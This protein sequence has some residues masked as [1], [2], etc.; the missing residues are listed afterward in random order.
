MVSVNVTIGPLG[1]GFPGLLRDFDAL[2]RLKPSASASSIEDNHL[3]KKNSV[4]RKSELTSLAVF[5]LQFL[6]FKIKADFFFV[7]F[8]VQLGFDC[9]MNQLYYVL[10]Y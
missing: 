9:I 7:S 5:P 3:S 1:F 4:W 2:F 6:F 10:L 8:P